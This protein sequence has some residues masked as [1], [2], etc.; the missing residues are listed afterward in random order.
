[1]DDPGTSRG[2]SEPLDVLEAIATT[3]AIRRIRPDPVSDDDL[4]AVLFAATRAPSGSNRQPFRFLVLRDGPLAA[5][6][7]ALLARGF[8]AG[9]DAKS[10]ADGYDTAATGDPTS[11]KARMAKTM[12]E[13]VDTFQDV[14]VVVLPCLVR[15]REPSSYEGASIYPACQNLLLAAR[16]RGLGGVLT[17]WHALVEDEL[18]ALLDIPDGVF[19]AAT[20][21]LGRPRGG[22]GPVRRRPLTDFVYDD[23]WGQPAPWLPTDS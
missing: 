3:R 6:A 12:R 20:I 14:P 7:K 22:H 9:W 18:R 15:Y 4:A 21:P 23:R 5:Q 19:I 17:E 1:V 16:A 11:R 10:A 13:F 8:R 2:S